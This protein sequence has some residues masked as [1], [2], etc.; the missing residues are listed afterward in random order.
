[1]TG[2]AASGGD[3]CGG[4]RIGVDLMGVRRFAPIAAHER[5]RALLFTPAELAQASGLALDLYTQRLASRFSAKEAVCKVLG[6]GFCQGLVWRDI[7]VLADRWG[8]PQVTLTGGARLVAEQAGVRHIALTL[9]HQ[10]DL[11]IAVAVASCHPVAG[12]NE[13]EDAGT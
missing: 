12:S 6:R 13:D 2:S 4:T 11:V 8:A 10:Q 1:M 7:E 9:T 5:Y 3:R